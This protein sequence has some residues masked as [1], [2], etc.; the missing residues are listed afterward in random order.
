MRAKLHLAVPVPAFPFLPCSFLYD[1]AH[2]ATRGMTASFDVAIPT[3]LF[4]WL[5]IVWGWS[6]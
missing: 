6:R 1:P 2:G 3:W 5:P 4:V